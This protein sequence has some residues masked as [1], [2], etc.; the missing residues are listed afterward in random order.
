MFARFHSKL[1]RWPSGWVAWG[2]ACVVCVWAIAD[3]VWLNAA[4]GIGRSTYDN[5]VRLR[6]FAAPPDPRIVILDIDEASL[7]SMSKEFGRWPWPRDTLATVLQHIEAQG[8][9]AIVWDISF[10][11]PDRLSPGGDAAFAKAAQAST[12]SHFSVVR[13]P[14]FNDAHSQLSTAELPQLWVEPAWLG[15]AAGSKATVAVVAP[16]FEALTKS[17]LGLNNAEPERDGVIR[18]YRLAQV[19]PDGSALK[20][21]PLSVALGLAEPSQQRRVA[22]DAVAAGFALVSWRKQVGAYPRLRF[23][24]VFA[25]AE[26]AK[27][28]S[29]AE[30]RFT[31]KVVIVGSTAPSLHDIHPTPLSPTMP[32]V[33]SLATV[34]DNA[35]HQRVQ[36]QLP[37]EAQTALAALLCL[38]MVWS[39]RRRGSAGVGRM[40]LWLPAALLC[41]SFVSV[42][43]P[44]FLDLHLA[45][46]FGMALLAALGAWDAMRRAHWMARISDRGVDAS[47]DRACAVV[48]LRATGVIDD[49]WLHRL[50][51]ALAHEL[52]TARV[53]ST[54]AAVPMFGGYA[55]PGPAAMISLLC[56]ASQGAVA[57]GIL[58]RVFDSRHS[59]LTIREPAAEGVKT[60][61]APPAISRTIFEQWARLAGVEPSASSER[62]SLRT[63]V[64]E[65]S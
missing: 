18:R 37:R 17:K 5:M 21:M 48:S 9:A 60:A 6:L 15:Q 26:A 50:L 2:L 40:M 64:I 32:G 4:T 33:E 24:D 59:L 27:P 10:A 23:A 39:T 53:V 28:L 52:P 63:Q 65:H 43:T 41:L 36:H 45:L 46:G 42:H 54:Q 13:L 11:D 7:A 51:D 35:L 58:E 29:K 56:D 61:L 19:L 34:I 38:S 12:K 8:P 57:Q 31:G 62:S 44:L 25:E 20:S 49:A 16:A 47:L 3:A 30:T 14:A 22:Q 55:W 1:A